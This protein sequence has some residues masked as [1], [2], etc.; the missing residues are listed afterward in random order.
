VQIVLKD[1][2]LTNQGLK[3]EHWL[4]VKLFNI[5]SEYVLRE[6]HIDINGTLFHMSVQTAAY[7][8]D[9]NIMARSFLVVNKICIKLEQVVEDKGLEINEHKTNVMIKACGHY[10]Q[11]QNV[12]AEDNNFDRGFTYLG[13]ILAKE[14]N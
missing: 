14:G 9:I 7:G 3:E 5:V 2:V 8:D 11:R 1:A 13:S 12:T 6:R 10:K 4:A